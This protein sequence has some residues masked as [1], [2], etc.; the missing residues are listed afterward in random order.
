M[1]AFLSKVFSRKDKDKKKDAED[2]DRIPSPSSPTTRQHSQQDG[3]DVADDKD[4]IG[5]GLFRPK[6]Q[7][8]RTASASSTGAKRVDDVP[9][10]K[11]NLDLPIL[12]NQSSQDSST[13]GF[14]TAEGEA[15]FRTLFVDSVLAGM[16][17]DDTALGEARLSPA[18]ALS[19]MSACVKYITER[20]T[21]SSNSISLFSWHL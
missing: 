5:L 2:K 9:Q 3:Q 20:G 19:L 21:Y 17:I 8:T 13:L 15:D 18:E 6:S 1:A 16:Q 4:K 10:L 14:T 12:R 11:L 7:H